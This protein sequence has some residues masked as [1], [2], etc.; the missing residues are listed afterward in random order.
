VGIP[1]RELLAVQV[2]QVELREA[3]DRIRAV[4]ERVERL[5]DELARDADP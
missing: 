5:R 4:V 2:V 1:P 3:A